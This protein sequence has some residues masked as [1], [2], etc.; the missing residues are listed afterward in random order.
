MFRACVVC[1]LWLASFAVLGVL[2]SGVSAQPAPAHADRVGELVARGLAYEQ[3]GDPSSALGF[4]RDAVTAGPRDERGYAALGAG[5]L[6]LSEWSR[7]QETFEAGVRA[8]PSS[9][10]LWFGLYESERNMNRSP[11]ALAALRAARSAQPSSVR[12]LT[13]LAD[14]ASELGLW[15]DALAATRTLAALAV[16]RPNELDANTWRLR[17]RALELILGSS[18]RVHHQTCPAATAVLSALGRCP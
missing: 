8:V 18:E 5:Y 10:K 2:A 1:W 11:R 9:E 14:L 16:T 12:V 6:A 15:S 7:A 17:T 13:A 3:R 4:F